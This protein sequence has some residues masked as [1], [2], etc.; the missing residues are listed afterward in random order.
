MRTSYKSRFV[1]ILHKF[2]TTY[3]LIVETTYK[4]TY[5][6][7]FH[8]WMN[9]YPKIIKGRVDFT[10]FF[11]LN[12]MNKNKGLCYIS[13][14]KPLK[15]FTNACFFSPFKT[16]HSSYIQNKPPSPFKWFIIHSYGYFRDWIIFYKYVLQLLLAQK[17]HTRVEGDRNTLCTSHRMKGE[18]LKPKKWVTINIVIGVFC[19]LGDWWSCYSSSSNSLFT[20]HF[21]C[22]ATICLKF[23]DN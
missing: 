10:L 2:V 6:I 9:K 14:I 7:Y 1:C 12:E 11:A 15:N 21:Y 18:C 8:W 22:T 16:F 19:E 3:K 23:Y 20:S 13:R 17:N 4:S 5:V